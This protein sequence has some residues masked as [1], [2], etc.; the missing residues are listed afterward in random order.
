[1]TLRHLFH[2]SLSVFSFSAFT[3]AAEPEL[4]DLLRQGLY[5]EEVSR[6]PVA[7]AAH[8]EQIVARFHGQQA[9]A[10]T[11]LF[12]LAEVRRGQDKKDDAIKLYQQLLTDFPKAEAEG[13]LARQHLT[14]LGGKIPEAGMAVLDEEEQEIARLKTLLASS[15]DVFKMD[16]ISQY[17]KMP[18]VLEF[19]LNAGM[20]VGR[21]SLRTAP[22]EQAAES[23]NLASVR[24]LLDRA[25][26]Q[27]KPYLDR[28]LADAVKR[29]FLEVARVLLAAGAKPVWQPGRVD[30]IGAAGPMHC[31]GPPLADAIYRMRLAG[32]A[33]GTI[34]LLLKA[35]ADVNQPA[36]ETTLTPLHFAALIRGDDGT[37]LAKRL[38]DLGATL[39]ALSSKRWWVAGDSQYPVSPLMLAVMCGNWNTARL[40]L[41][42]GAKA[43]PAEL[44]RCARMPQRDSAPAGLW[45]APTG[46]ILQFLL[47]AGHHPDTLKDEECSALEYSVRAGA[48][49]L[50]KLM[51]DH[52]A[53][54]NIPNAK[55]DPP[56]LSI[57]KQDNVELLKLFLKHGADANIK[58]AGWKSL[59]EPGHGDPFAKTTG[60]WEEVPGSLLE[61][62]KTKEPKLGL[63]II[64]LLLDAGAKADGWLGSVLNRVALLDET[65]ELVRRLLAQR[66][67]FLNLEEVRGL[68]DW[69]PAARRI[70]LDEVL[71]PALTKLPG[72]LLF[73]ATTGVSQPLVAPD[74][75][76]PLPST[77]ELLLARLDALLPGYRRLK[78]DGN[79]MVSV[80]PIE[81]NWPTL[82]L[83]R[84]GAN[85]ALERRELDLTGDQPLPALQPG[86]ILELG[87]TG[88]PTTIGMKPGIPQGGIAPD[89]A[90]KTTLTWHLRKR[91]TFPV[92]VTLDGQTRE[93]KLRGDLLVFD[94]TKNEA[95]LLTAG[96]LARVLLPDLS[97]TSSYSNLK[98]NT[99]LTVQRQGMPE[100]RMD[101]AAA[102]A[103][104]F[105]LQPG[106]HLIL[107]D[108]KSVMAQ[109]ARPGHEP[110][111]LVTPG[112]PYERVYETQGRTGADS[113]P[114]KSPPPT[115][116][117]LLTDAYFPLEAGSPFLEENLDQADYPTLMKGIQ[118]ERVPVIPP[119]P[120]FAHI[121]IKRTG[122]DGQEAVLEVDLSD[123]IRR[124]ADDTPIAEA[125]QAD[126]ELQPGD[127]VE[128]PLK[129]G[130]LAQPWTG[131][132][133]DEERF[134]RKA[135]GGFF[136]LKTGDGVIERR[137]I[138]YHQPE[139]RQT[140]H[141]LLPL[142]PRQGVASTRATHVGR[143]GTL[144]KVVRGNDDLQMDTAFVRDGDQ[145][146]EGSRV[147]NPFPAIRNNRYVP[148][149]PATRPETTRPKTPDNETQDE[150]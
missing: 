132:S 5:A 99:I 28:A 133:A 106:D 29:N 60:K 65:G 123:A 10:A 24:L 149:P 23:G 68:K 46:A 111:W 121:R 125:R 98:E 48:A 150:K 74:A 59:R 7:A 20:S 119:H 58:I 9:I 134:F 126:V 72:P 122:A 110:I 11:A 92:T 25:P 127:V 69:Q 101:L 16:D 130:Q 56:L 143:V 40:L 53:N 146:L 131:F 87:R 136:T 1:M 139:W 44:W 3:A 2:C 135:L 17:V 32:K 51:L 47:E 76:G 26:D 128:L 39:D 81:F 113:T 30:T 45:F 43:D 108:S 79:R 77:P 38:V 142:P 75:A 64:R 63:E 6:D 118:T 105:E 22:I 104:K 4:N 85:H 120:D 95:P 66:P 15:P 19:A 129:T 148:P 124:C 103:H 71:I 107:P 67:D 50:I 89:A 140:P 37:A 102:A 52:G 18:K 12:R 33:D 21:R 34:D 147:I 144:S 14:E 70:F 41:K 55:G 42:C 73:S 114:L 82:T 27:A 54:P 84:P 78:N 97:I 100:L 93:F 90:L 117:Q 31:W 138:L 94:P 35:K 36:I 80:E 96:R 109:A 112:F 57:I 137:E 145:L 49:D 116:I 8:Y 115:L 91:I 62:V 61:C 141:G 86:D 88:E 83:V 13:K